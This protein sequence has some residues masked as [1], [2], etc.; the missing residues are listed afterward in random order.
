MAS[1]GRIRESRRV[2]HRNDGA[3]VVEGTLVDEERK[4]LVGTER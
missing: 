3:E 1:G 2:L 4:F